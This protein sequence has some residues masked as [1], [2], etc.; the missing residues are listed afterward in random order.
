M[1]LLKNRIRINQTLMKNF[2]AG[3]VFFPGNR[4]QDRM[5]WPDTPGIRDPA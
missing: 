5:A 3:S 2:Q 4:D 1:T